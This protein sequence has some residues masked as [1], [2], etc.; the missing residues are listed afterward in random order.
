MD[1]HAHWLIRLPF[2]V[3]FI[4]HGAGKVI[5]PVASADMLGLSPALLFLV[6]AA[7]LL[8]GFGALLGGLGHR[9]APLAT[10]LAGVAAVPV[11]VGAIA[12]FHWP[13][14][15]FVPSETHPMGGMEFQLM[16][17]GVATWFL[18]GGAAPKPAPDVAAGRIGARSPSAA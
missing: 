1:R 6:G 10:R 4:G 3:T 8:A 5:M 15:S 18:M 13:R 11:L 9:L 12:L 7:E 2:A 17:L 14:W 16:L